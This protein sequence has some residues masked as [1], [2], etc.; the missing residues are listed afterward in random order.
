[1]KHLLFLAAFV[2]VASQAAILSSKSS[3]CKDFCGGFCLD[4]CQST[5]A[6]PICLGEQ[7]QCLCAQGKAPCNA[8]FCD[9]YCSTKAQTRKYEAKCD[10]NDCKC[11]FEMKELPSGFKSK[12]QPA[13]ITYVADKTLLNAEFKCTEKFCN[14]YC[15]LRGEGRKF[16]AY[17]DQTQSCHCEYEQKPLPSL[18]SLVQNGKLSAAKFECTKEWCSTYCESKSNGRKFE[19]DCDQ[20]TQSCKCQYPR[21]TFIRASGGP[22]RQTGSD[23]TTLN[24]RFECTKEFCSNYCESKSNGRKFEAVCGSDNACKCEYAWQPTGRRTVSVGSTTN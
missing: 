20:S 4:S 8:T 12:L 14:D 5:L 11:Q 22:D 1:M 3:S 13:N 15:T 19:A 10:G 6:T 18:S 2:V 16:K 17:C 21:Q 7:C 24:K 9:S 23:S